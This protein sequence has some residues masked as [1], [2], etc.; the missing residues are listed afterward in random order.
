KGLLLKKYAAEAIM[1]ADEAGFSVKGLGKSEE[2]IALVL[3]AIRNAGYKPGRDIK[4][5]LDAAA[6]SFYNSEKNVYEFQGK[7]LSSAQMV[8]FYI[9]L[10]EQYPGVILSIEDGMAENDWAGWALFTAAMKERGVLTIGDDLFVTQ[11]VRL[12]KG[13]AGNSAT[14]ILI[15]VNQ[16]GTLGGT[17]DVMKT[18][19]QNG[20]KAVVSHRSGETL[21]DGIADLAY[22]T[23]ALG[24]K[25][26]DPQPGYDFPN[27][28][29]WVRRN[30]Y[31]RMVEIQEKEAV[32]QK[33]LVVGS[34]FFAS[35]GSV[36]ALKQALVLNKQV[37]VVLYGE[38][39]GS[40][41]ALL[42][43]ASILTAPTLTGAVNMLKA[44]DY[45][46]KNI[47]VLGSAAQ[48]DA[49][50]VK[51]IR[52]IP[53]KSISTIALAQALNALLADEAT[54]AAF[55][56]FDKD[57]AEFKLADVFIAEQVDQ[58]IRE[59]EEFFTKV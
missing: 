22:A 15:K 40:V 5:A 31:L 8:Q 54:Q 39:M 11:Q 43:D 25:T 20:M 38:S 30:K 34:D 33:A 6:T 36:N 58:A 27:N 49:A 59:E 7:E 21:D 45:P 47:V 28:D 12:Q 50:A 14:A 29:Q 10:V 46:A 53:V 3:E 23:R 52:Q 9:E 41:K 24:L 19:K 16:N 51:D 57:I 32:S 2:A 26:G 18:A 17:L 56:Q 4:L 35:G 13:I 42:G 1:R 48:E 37:R 55:A 44:S